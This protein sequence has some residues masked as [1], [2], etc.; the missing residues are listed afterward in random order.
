MQTFKTRRE[1]LQSLEEDIREMLVTRT[2]LSYRDLAEVFDVST[3]HI[4]RIAKKH[5]IKRG[6]G[7]PRSGVG[8]N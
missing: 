6:I 2:D 8:R 4:K 3:S 7:R 5:G 1:A